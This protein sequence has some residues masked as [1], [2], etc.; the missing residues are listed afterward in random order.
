MRC[1]RCGNENSDGNRFC[2]MCGAT[3][4]AK[5]QAA[6]SAAPPTMSPPE[7]RGETP[8]IR[9]S[10]EVRA[11]RMFTPSAPARS[12]S[13]QVPSGAAASS[14]TPAVK[15][16][17]AAPPAN[18]NP[19]ISGPSFL[20]LN[21]PAD[22]GG[23]Y[24]RYGR[25]GND[26]VRGSSGNLDYLL[27][28]ED[29]EEPKRGW[30]KFF[31]VVVALAL[32]GGFGYLRWKQGGFDWLLNDKKPAAVESAPSGTDSGSAPA[33][34]SGSGSTSSENTS[35]VSSGSASPNASGAGSANSSAPNSNSTTPSS[36]SAN[37][38]TPD[39]AAQPVAP[40]A[41][42]SSAASDT[43]SAPT[44]A[45]PP[46]KPAPAASVSPDAPGKAAQPDSADG[47]DS[48]DSEAPAANTK[49]TAATRTRVPKPTPV[50]PLDPTVEAERYLYG[51]GVRQDCDRGL[52]LLKPAAAQ[53][54]VKA[55]IS[56]GTLYS[57]GTCTPRDLPTAYRWYALALHKQPDNQSLQDDLQN[58][59]GKMTQPER[60]LAIKLSQ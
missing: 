60:Q 46:A 48:T 2:G 34:S 3:L 47:S 57:S 53:S 35:P 25:G 15:E 33:A 11:P 52:R 16:P 9:P 36:A 4:V 41:S 23:D 54:N 26:Q 43:T 14:G 31:L 42:P 19:I 51:N 27:E 17:Y 38:A 24:S 29:E 39:A 30:G 32:A 13:D 59:W 49:P 50:T 37:P 12:A 7:K 22:G 21:K 1:P 5:T 8:S 40:N 20:G 56:L 28:D 55:M 58:L 44:A 6:A 45:A 10:A 18:Q